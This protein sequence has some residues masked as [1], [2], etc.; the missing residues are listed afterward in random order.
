MSSRINTQK[1]SATCRT[2]TSLCLTL[3]L[4]TLPSAHLRGQTASTTETTISTDRPS[5]ANSSSVVPKGVF[6]LENGFLI[7]N[8]QRQYLLDLPET[9]LRFG[10]LD[11]TELRLSVPNYFHSVTTNSGT[12][13]GFG[14]IALGVKLQISPLPEN[15][16]L[17]VIVFLSLPT[18]ANALSSHGY[19]AGLQ[20]PW[21]RQLSQNWTASG[22]VAFYW[23]T[24]GGKHDFTGETTFVFD[25]QLT[26]T[27][28]AFVEYAGDFPQNGGS[29]QIL[30]FGSAYKLSTR[31]Q[32]DFQIAAGLS[33]AAPDKFFGVGYSFFFQARK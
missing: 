8:A 9:A 5:I 15:F 10:L 4:I 28:D 13:S 3:L 25:R 20:L 17:S 32:I 31:Q 23:P 26:K 24:V 22:Q 18:G 14:D 33:H 21:S 30:H 12:I 6:Q 11:K 1:P 29:R 19:D 16:N 27:W 7:T 2:R